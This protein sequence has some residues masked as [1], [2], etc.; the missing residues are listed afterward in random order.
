MLY[1][2]PRY[3]KDL[4][5]WVR[6][7]S[8]NA[9]RTFRALAEFGAP[10]AGIQPTEFAKDDLIYQLGV[11]PSRID[12]VTS[13]SGVMFDE[14]WSRRQ[15]ADFDNVAAHFISLADLLANKRA[16]GRASDLV[17]CERLEEAEGLQ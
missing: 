13:I 9:D 6:P 7:T 15:N 16:T 14:A 3:T 2:E 8:E 17:D 5:V 12:V 4:D 10:L 1:T 11:P